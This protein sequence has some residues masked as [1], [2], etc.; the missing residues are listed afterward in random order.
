MTAFVW[1]AATFLS[2]AFL[3]HAA[4]GCC[5]CVSWRDVRTGRRRTRYGWIKKVPEG[6]RN[7]SGGSNGGGGGAGGAI[8]EAKGR[9]L[10]ATR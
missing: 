2:V 4:M 3:I 6:C 7:E 8:A 9:R 10:G 5:I 1:I